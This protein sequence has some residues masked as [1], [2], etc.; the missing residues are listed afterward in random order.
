MKSVSPITRSSSVDVDD[1]EVVGRDRSQA[2]GVGRIGLLRPLP[3]AV[4]E[5]HEAFLGEHGEDLLHVDRAERVRRG[6]R[7]L[8]RGA[9]HVVEQNVQVVRIDERVL[10]RRAEE[11][12]GI[13]HDEL[14]DGRA[15][16]DEHGRRSTGTAARAPRALPGRGD[17]AR[18]AGHHGH[19]E[20][21]DV[22]AE[23][24][25][26]G[27]H[28]AAHVP[29]A[30]PALDLAAS[31]RQIA[32]AI[33]ANHVGRPR[34]ARKRVL[35]I[36][37]QDLRRETALREDDHLQAALQELDRDAPRFGEI[38][39][40]DAQLRVDDRRI[41]EQK[42]L[43]A[44]RRAALAHFR[45]RR[46]DQPLRQLARIR[47]RRRRADE[48][49]IRSVVPADALEPPHDVAEMAAED[50]AIRVQ[51][52]DD[53]ELQILEELRPARMVRQDPRVHHVGIAQHDV[54]ARRESRGARPA[55]C[56]RRT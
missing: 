26:V 3:R 21:A 25:R 31:E 19:V 4:D 38:R 33:P 56:R 24:E 28:D 32:A 12:L 29:A 9:L 17:R 40:P 23:L 46:A 14:I 50:A 37:R 6:E 22:D 11:I 39:P 20:R 47:D 55:A 44:A 36:R 5:V 2:D 42:E 1:D 53:D 48:R 49:R 15:G 52:V 35:Q 41:D 18:I 16:G 13:A 51:L 54:R 10:G 34:R 45:K 43:L 8:E 30:Q 27:R 7:Q